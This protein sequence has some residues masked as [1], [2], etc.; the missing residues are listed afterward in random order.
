MEIATSAT[1]A[2]RDTPR[3]RRTSGASSDSTDEDDDRASSGENEDSGSV[4]GMLTFE[5]I[6]GEKSPKKGDKE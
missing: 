4:M 6:Y 2:S 1:P 3:R 5:K